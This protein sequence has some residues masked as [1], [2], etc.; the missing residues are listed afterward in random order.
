MTEGRAILPGGTK[1]QLNM[2]KS[3]ETEMITA[4]D[5]TKSQSKQE[6]FDT[7]AS[8][9]FHEEEV[10]IGKYRLS[11]YRDGGDWAIEVCD[12]TKKDED[13][14]CCADAYDTYFYW[15]AYN[16]AY[17][18]E[19]MFDAISAEF[20]DILDQENELGEMV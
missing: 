14:Y 6:L 3:L 20:P 7:I 8:I 13:G 15:D 19:E 18:P 11:S 1:N 10:M 17:T 5:S 2:L 9:F 4:Q 12:T 16:L